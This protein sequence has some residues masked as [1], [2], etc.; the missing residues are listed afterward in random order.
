[1]SE[2]SYIVLDIDK[3]TNT[4]K[5]FN[6]SYVSGSVKYICLETK[7]ECLINEASI[8]CVGLVNNNFLIADLNGCYLFDPNGKFIKQIGNKGEGPGEHMNIGNVFY[9]DQSKQIFISST[10]SYA[11]GILVFDE[12][13]NYKKT[14]LP[15]IRISD[16]T[17]LHDSIIVLNIPNYTG[18][19]ENKTA[20][21]SRNGDTLSTKANY[22]HFQMNGSPLSLNNRAVFYPYDNEKYYLRTFNDT[23]YRIT[24]SCELVPEYVFSSSSHKVSDK[25]RADGGVFAGTDFDFIIPWSVIETDRFL[26]ISMFRNKKGLIPYFYD[27]KNKEFFSMST[28]SDL[29]GFADDLSGNLLSVYPQ[30]ILTD[31][32]VCTL[33][34]PNTILKLKEKNPDIINRDFCYLEED[35]NPVLSV[36]E[37]F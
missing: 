6:L 24:G 35:S 27:K 37:V 36:I 34:S 29:Y 19:S 18:N 9:D 4:Q 13:G 10:Y 23:I 14:I 16:W 22:D 33:L 2:H 11:D 1:M 30:Y 5:Q 26:F 7:D 3:A 31:N 8:V 15:N 21:I 25:L 32:L 17:V 28:Q 12:N 20:F